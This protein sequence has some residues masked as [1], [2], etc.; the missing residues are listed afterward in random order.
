MKSEETILEELMLA[1]RRHRLFTANSFPR[2]VWHSFRESKL[3]QR[4]RRFWVNFRRYRLISRIVTVT[5][6]L[7]TV[8]GTGAAMLILALIALLILPIAVLLTGGTVLLGWFC[9][10]RQN[11][12]LRNE[13]TD[14]T[15]YLFFPS[16]IEENTFSVF[17]MR[18]LSGCP[19]SAVFIVSPHLWSSRGVGGKGFYINARRESD[20]LFL[21]RR[22]YFFFFRRLLTDPKIK[23]IV[24]IL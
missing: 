2:Y 12:L 20:H 16:S 1:R 15:V 3:Y 21:L 18:Q 23:R 24:V 5:A 13:V 22:H 14:R 19:Q 8:M 11:E 10:R 7:L 9:R 17:T 4:V 6:T